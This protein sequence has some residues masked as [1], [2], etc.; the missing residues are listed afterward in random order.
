MLVTIYYF[1]NTRTTQQ[2]KNLA[3]DGESLINRI[4]KHKDDKLVS[5]SIS[6]ENP[7]N[8]YDYQYDISFKMSEYD[9][10]ISIDPTSYYYDLYTSGNRFEIPNIAFLE[11]V[12]EWNIYPKID[13]FIVNN[14][15]STLSIN[16]LTINVVSSEIDP[17]PY[18]YIA[19]EYAYTNK[20]VIANESW[21]E[22]ESA[23]LEYSILKKGEN[24]NGAYNSKKVIP[25]F[26]DFY[27]IDFIQD[28]I[29]IGYDYTKVKSI[30]DREG[31]EDE[32]V[33]LW[34]NQQNYNAYRDIFSPFEIGIEYIN[35]GGRKIVDDYE[36]RYSG[37]A[38]IY[39]KLSIP[40]KSFSNEFK[41][42]INLSSTGE[43][44]AGMDED[45]S[46]DVELKPVGK[47]Y[48]IKFP[49]ITTIEPE[50]SERIGLTILC[51]KSSLHSMTIEAVND[52]GLNIKSKEIKL[53][54]LN[55]KHSSKKAWPK[56]KNYY[57]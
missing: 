25:Y 44:G 15:N 49:N 34:I 21:N 45:D 39:G 51:P 17:L 53:H 36:N 28:L 29:A 47:N 22:W 10:Y 32:F 23:I 50:D 48:K 7:E 13:C 24:F 12:T 30:D 57:E 56:H 1:I 40:E 19:S 52:N 16:E 2:E 54:Y 14:T 37:F 9:D 33:W 20:L 4:S 35:K 46:F 38:R 41:G 18:L 26:K 6:L 3:S 42:R 55:P 5:L 31:N 11:D 8:Y 27:R 43:F